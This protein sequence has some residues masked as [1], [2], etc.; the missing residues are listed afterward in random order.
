M[1]HGISKLNQMNTN[2]LTRIFALCNRIINVM[3]QM[4]KL[5]INF[6]KKK[7]KKKKKKLIINV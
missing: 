1:A 3:Y 2:S 6:G 7:K 5:E 4:F